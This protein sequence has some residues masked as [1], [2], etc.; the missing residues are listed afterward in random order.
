[1][2]QRFCLIFISQTNLARVQHVVQAGMLNKQGNIEH[3]MF[4]QTKLSFF[5]LSL[6]SCQ[7]S[8]S[9]Q[10]TIYL[11]TGRGI[12]LECQKTRSGG[13]RDCQ[14]TSSCSNKHRFG[15]AD[16]AKITLQ[17]HPVENTRP[18]CGHTNTPTSTSFGH[19][20]VEGYMRTLIFYIV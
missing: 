14:N 18:R 3:L 5:S 8:M 10:R 17:T 20:F 9:V 7:R 2:C 16:R 15:W 4:A 13:R 6:M 12:V 19:S 11:G 1:M